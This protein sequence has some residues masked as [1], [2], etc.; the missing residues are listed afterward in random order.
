[1]AS[2]LGIGYPPYGAHS[3]ELPAHWKDLF[4]N[5]VMSRV[6][7]TARF[8]FVRQR[9]SAVGFPSSCHSHPW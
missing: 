6:I 2:P 3:N 1:M 8:I 9:C 4:K 5:L 7:F